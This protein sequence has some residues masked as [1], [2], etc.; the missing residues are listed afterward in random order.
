[1][2]WG[3]WILRNNMDGNTW[4]R[5][6]S[7]VFS[8]RIIKVLAIL[9]I[10]ELF[11]RWKSVMVL[12]YKLGNDLTSAWRHFGIYSSMHSPKSIEAFGRCICLICSHV[13]SHHW[14]DTALSSILCYY[15][16]E[17]ILHTYPI[18][19]LCLFIRHSLGFYY[20]RTQNG[21]PI[22][23]EIHLRRLFVWE[24]HTFNSNWLKI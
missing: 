8:L 20:S 9:E 6:K 18:F 12:L 23:H 24:N 13:I 1:M 14:F 19:I 3:L 4:F 10:L 16:I 15:F 17:F 7:T 2:S 11:Q 21:W 5:Y 22:T